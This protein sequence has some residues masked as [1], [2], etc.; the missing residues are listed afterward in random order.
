MFLSYKLISILQCQVQAAQWRR[1]VPAQNRLAVVANVWYRSAGTGF[2]G[3]VMAE[4]L[5]TYIGDNCSENEIASI[6][7]Y[8][9]G[10]ICM[11]MS[12]QFHSNT[13]NEDDRLG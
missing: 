1:I 9:G 7:L 11:F 6:N 8:E 2:D 3:W 12:K 5:N 13:E 10:Y 4:W